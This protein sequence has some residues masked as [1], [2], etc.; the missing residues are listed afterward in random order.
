MLSEGKQLNR[1]K[2]QDHF[3]PQIAAVNEGLDALHALAAIH[4]WTLTSWH[5]AIPHEA[6]HVLFACFHKTLL[7]LHV[8][9]ELTLDGLYGLA[10]PH[11][12]HAFESMMIAKLCATDPSS[13]I[14]D[15]WIDGIDLYFTNGIIRR[16]TH[17][18]TSQFVESWGLLCRWSH[19]TVYAAQFSMDLQTTTDE[20]GVNLAF[21]GVLLNFE[22]HLLSRHILTPTVRYYAGRYGS[23]KRLADAKL[24]V[25]SSLAILREI[26][27]DPSRRLV[28]DFRATWVLK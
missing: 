27:G 25:R 8:A 9:L 16:I 6:N 18:D 26:L 3:Q 10:R 14:F 12:R 23:K 28:R 4:A 20:S 1:T 22:D 11:L 13:D 2:L 21:I 7:S 24:G 19:A 5:D 15:K 17:P